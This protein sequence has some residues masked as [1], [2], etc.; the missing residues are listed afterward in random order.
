VHQVDVTDGGGRLGS[1][2]VTMP[3]G[4]DLRRQEQRLLVDLADQTAIVFRNARMEAEL[5]SHVEELDRQTAELGASYRRLLEAGDA[6][7]RRLEAAISRDVL[8]LLTDL[9]PTLDRL[10]AG[11]DDG[12]AP[13]TLDRLVAAA[14]TALE[15]LRDLTRGICPALLG[16]AGVGPAL[17]S[18]LMRAG[19]AVPLDIDESVGGRRFPARIE[20]AVYYCCS[21]AVAESGADAH[22]RVAV[23]D[24]DLVL[25]VTGADPAPVVRQAMVDRV[26][27]LRG[28]LTVD[29]GPVLRVRIPL[30]A[31]VSS[32]PA[33]SPDPVAT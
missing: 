1:I 29:A 2:C 5:A 3:A 9:P 8:P 14:T 7:R 19:R 22:V 28:S 6:E 10:R 21:E 30:P 15:V 11:D 18:C 26:E 20:A 31:A 4:R 16:R 24:E 23:I 32:A 25:T 17:S 27:A 12:S 13:Q 33:L